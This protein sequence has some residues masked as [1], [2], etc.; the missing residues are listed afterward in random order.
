[1]K[2]ND[3][4]SQGLI[5]QRGT[6]DIIIN[7]D[8]ITFK[9]HKGEDRAEINV[10]ELIDIII[11]N[12][13]TKPYTL[14][15][16]NTETNTIAVAEVERTFYFKPDNVNQ[17]V[18]KIKGEVESNGEFT[19][20]IKHPYPYNLLVIEEMYNI[21]KEAGPAILVSTDLLDQAKSN[22]DERNKKFVQDFYKLEENNTN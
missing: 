3:T 15:L 6:Y 12:V 2:E 20:N 4:E 18:D 8:K 7:D 11:K 9:C 16:V 17:L 22:I 19:L 10:D 14:G 13:K 5:A 21:A 1:M